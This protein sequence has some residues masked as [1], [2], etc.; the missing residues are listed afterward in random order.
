MKNMKTEKKKTTKMKMMTKGL[1][2][3]IKNKNTK[4]DDDEGGRWKEKT[5]MRKTKKDLRNLTKETSRAKDTDNSCSG[6]G[7]GALNRHP[8]TQPSPRTHLSGE[9]DR[10]C[11]GEAALL[12]ELA[13]E[14]G[15]KAVLVCGVT[16]EATTLLRNLA[17]CCS[18]RISS[19]RV[20]SVSS[21]TWRRSRKVR[22]T[23]CIVL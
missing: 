20:S 7:G 6:G 4:I 8:H 10:L 22:G 21:L 13:L 9:E 1:R 19:T 12:G 23:L 17:S 2:K 18:L 16:M 11:T 14:A 15:L 5:T 3:T